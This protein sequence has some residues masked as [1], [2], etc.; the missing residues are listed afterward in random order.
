MLTPVRRLRALL[1]ASCS[2][3]P[4]LAVGPAWAADILVNSDATLRSAI[5]SASSGDRIVFQNNIALSADLPAVQTNVAIV[6]NGNTLSGSNQ[7]RGL[8]IGAFSGSTQVPIAVTVQ[9]LA[10]TNTTAQ[11]GAGATGSAGAGGG[12][13]LGGA[14]FVANQ[15]TVT[16]SNVSLT[17][18][19]A[20]G[21]N[22]GS[23]GS[24]GFAGGGG[25]GGNGA[26]G[27]NGGAGGGGGGLGRGANGGTADVNG[28]PGIASGASPAGFGGDAIA[29]GGG[30]GG[31]GGAAAGG[32]GGGAATGVSSQ[33]ASNKAAAITASVDLS[34]NLIPP[35]KQ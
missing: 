22:G 35:E 32:G 11:G 21:G 14:L 19:A 29:L 33:A 23:G 30:P 26:S 20:I 10:I 17:G 3:A 18:N 13:G 8:F 1:L 24:N 9:D 15:A 4:L 12:A 25:M 28:Q 7:F 5:T 16:V 2:L 31:S 34:M 27:G 6:G